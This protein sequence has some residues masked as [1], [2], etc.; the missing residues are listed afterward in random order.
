MPGG[1]L[2]S[3]VRSGQP[4]ELRADSFN[5]M[6]EGSELA[7]GSKRFS[8]GL[9]EDPR[10]PVVVK[11]LNS[12]GATLD[13]YAVVG[14]GDS[15]VDA[16]YI[17]L[18]EF[19]RQVALTAVT[20]T[21][22]HVGGRFAVLLEPIPVGEVGKAAVAGAVQCL[23]NKSNADHKW[24]DASPGHTSWLDSKGDSGAA[25][26]LWDSGGTGPVWA[27]VLL[28]RTAATAGANPVRELSGALIINAG[29]STYGFSYSN[30]GKI[31]W[32]SVPTDIADVGVQ[33]IG[34]SAPCVKF[35]NVGRYR[36]SLRWTLALDMT[37]VS[38]G[39]GFAATYTSDD[40]SPTHHHSYGKLNY[41][42]V[43][44]PQCRVET[45]TP[46]GTGWDACCSLNL[47][48]PLEY[49]TGGKI[50][51]CATAIFESTADETL[52]RFS[53]LV[54]DGPDWNVLLIEAGLVV[55]KLG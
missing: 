9:H 5:Y 19:G 17:N 23:V 37:S 13:Q 24:A 29:A 44:C 2:H 11:L 21:A 18:E 34:P 52:M 27:V 39:F 8:L 43:A 41:L 12:T 53:T 38:D 31:Q 33:V 30:P 22:D 28:G 42:G 48:S 54:T 7:H 46:P 4:L 50:N 35:L 55:E 45:Q 1:D 16:Q 6:L 20:P 3:R 10:N 26:I 36:L 47:A 51:S 14:I 25:M 40:G 15:L 32:Q 49:N